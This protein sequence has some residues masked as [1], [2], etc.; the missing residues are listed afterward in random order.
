MPIEIKELII[1]AI[2]SAK[3]NEP[4]AGMKPEDIHK[5]KKEITKEVT[6]K[7]LRTLRLKN[8]R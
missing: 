5:L 3:D 1:K 2:V 4:S 8:E 6:E 7:I